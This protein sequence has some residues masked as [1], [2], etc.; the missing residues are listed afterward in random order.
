MLKGFRVIQDFFGNTAP[1]YVDDSVLNVPHLP[2]VNY[3][4]QR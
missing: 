4:I 3:R 1:Q 2:A